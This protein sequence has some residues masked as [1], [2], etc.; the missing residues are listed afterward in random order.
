[1]AWMAEPT[2]TREEVERLRRELRARDAERFSL[3]RGLADLR[4]DLERIGASRAWR[5]GHAAALLLARVRRR[6]IVTEG[7]VSRALARLDEL[8]RVLTIPPRP[9]GNR[10]A[11]SFSINVAGTTREAARRGGDFAFATA[12][13]R[14]LERRGSRTRVQVV[15]AEED[16]GQDDV[17]IVLRG[18]TRHTPR[19]SQR[20]VLWVISHPADLS[21]DECEGYDLVCVA[22]AQFAESLRPETSAPVIVLDQATD[23][24]V[25]HPDPAPGV[26]HDLVFVGNSRGVRR[27][28]LE[29]LLPTDHGLAV[30]GSGWEGVVD[31]RYVTA[32]HVPNEELRRVYSSA[33][34]VLADHWDDMREFGFVANRIYDAVACGAFVISD[35]VDGVEERFGGAVC[36]YE[37]PEQLAQLVERFLADPDERR[38]RG[39]AGRARVLA[40]HTFDRRVE[41]LLAALERTE[42]VQTRG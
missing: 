16:L 39:A 21:P 32:T 22:S 25:F 6:P 7:A 42:G 18:R 35:P 10:N 9:A 33:S 28:V 36:T 1:M 38:V 34:I 27:R 31:A 11:P 12:M 19:A 37:S 14:A 24:D 4:A 15:P 26:A 30:Y 3:R 20:N 13:A 5:W 17:A 40:E 8:E 23:P 41:A 29:D 2:S